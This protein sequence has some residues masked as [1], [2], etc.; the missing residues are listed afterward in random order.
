MQHDQ[1]VNTMKSNVAASGMRHDRP[2]RFTAAAAI[3]RMGRHQAGVARPGD[4]LTDLAPGGPPYR[5]LWCRIGSGAPGAPPDERY[6]ADEVRPKD[7]GAGG[8]IEWESVPGGLEQAIVHNVAEAA[9]RTHLLEADTIVRVEER[10][11]RSGPPNMVYL[12]HV[13]VVQASRLARIVSYD[14]GSY[15]VQPV[16][17]SAGGLV[18]DGPEI[19]GVPN[20]GELWDDEK[21]YLA[22]PPSFDRIVELVSTP[23]GW[24]IVLHPPRMV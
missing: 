15:T 7:T 19:G 16:I 8:A 11:D 4:R 23:A 21:G 12:M 10:P 2:G 14:A 9:A 1:P 6:Y 13:P 17:R 18:D 5:L 24:T 22:G 3:G 20:L